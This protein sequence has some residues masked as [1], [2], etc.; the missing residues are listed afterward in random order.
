MARVDEDQLRALV[1][2]PDSKSVDIYIQSANVLVD[3]HLAILTPTPREDVLSLVELYLAAHFAV[4][5][6]EKGGLTRSRQGDSEDHYATNQKFGEGLRSTRYGQQA[7]AL[8]MSGTLSKLSEQSG[9]TA[10]KAALFRV[11]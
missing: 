5:S 1:D 2:V 8:D 9:S 4:L 10:R 3:S 7:L 11:L 6:E